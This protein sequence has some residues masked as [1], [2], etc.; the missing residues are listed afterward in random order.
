[1]SMKRIPSVSVRIKDLINGTFFPGSKEE[2]RSAYV[3]TPFGQKIS[4]ARVV[5]TVVEKFVSELGNYAFVDLDDNTGIIR[6]KK[7]G[8]VKQLANIEPGDVVLV[9]G[10]IKEYLDSIYINIE[11]IRKVD[12]K[13]ELLHNLRVIEKLKER[14]SIIEEIKQF[15]QSFGREKAIEFAMENFDMEK[16]VAKTIVDN[17]LDREKFKQKILKLIEELGKEEGVEIIKLLEILDVPEAEV[18]KA[19][20]ELLQEGSIFEVSPGVYKKVSS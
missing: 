9:V 17:F 1:M 10:K 14:K 15:Y 11:I 5:G 2:M 4:R 12:L 20:N 6:A 18:E 8:D 13:Y 19:I 7:F 3:I 16:E